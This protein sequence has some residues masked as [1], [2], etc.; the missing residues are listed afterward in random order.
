MRGFSSNVTLL[1]VL[2]AGACAE[3][4]KVEVGKNGGET[5]SPSSIKAAKGDVIE[6]VF[7][8]D[9]NVVAGDFKKPCTPLSSGGF[10]SGSL[11]SGKNVSLFGAL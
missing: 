10:Y 1:A 3:T 4:I 6:F 9:H 2:V 11:P 7:D 8:S 5:F